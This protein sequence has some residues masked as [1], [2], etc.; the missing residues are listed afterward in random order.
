[1]N[2]ARPQKRRLLRKSTSRRRASHKYVISTDFFRRLRPVDGPTPRHAGSCSVSP[3]S[4]GWPAWARTW[5]V[6]RVFRICSTACDR[7]F[8]RRRRRIRPLSCLASRTGRDQT[9]RSPAQVRLAAVLHCPFAR[10]SGACRGYGPSCSWSRGRTPC[11]QGRTNPQGATS[12]V[13]SC[14]Q[15]NEHRGVRD[16]AGGRLA[17]RMT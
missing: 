10:R 2:R 8:R 9:P 12:C 17:Q 5:P 11:L 14:K 7:P 6:S 1:M 15:I 13:L 3:C 16:V 4:C